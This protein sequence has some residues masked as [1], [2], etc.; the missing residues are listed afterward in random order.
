MN[1]NNVTM[2]ILGMRCGSCSSKVKSALLS[3]H[4]VDSV[5]V[6]FQKNIAVATTFLEVDKDLLRGAVAAAGEFSVEGFGESCE[7]RAHAL[8]IQTT[9]CVSD[10]SDVDTPSESLYPLFLIVGFILGVTLLIAQSTQDWSIESMMRHFMA[11]FFLVFSFFKLLNPSG[12]VSAFKMYD[13]LAKVIPGWAW[14]YPIVELFLGVA[15]LLAWFPALTNMLTL[16]LMVVGGGGVLHVLRQNKSIRCACLGTTLNLPMTKVTLVENGTMAAM[17]AVMLLGC[18]VTG[19][20]P[21]FEQF[22]LQDLQGLEITLMSIDGDRYPTKSPS[23]GADLLHGWT[24]LQRC[25]LDQH[26]Q[27]PHVLGILDQAMARG[28]RSVPVDCFNPRHAIRISSVESVKDFLICFQCRNYMVWV[29]GVRI[30]GGDIADDSK[31]T[32]NLIFESDCQHFSYH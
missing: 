2:H 18:G 20:R 31:D 3:V 8:P 23:I 7:S 24:V 16:F 5:Q 32:I 21:P 14:A 12:F 13:P 22:G 17:A 27:A 25:P 29:D 4:G 26:S 9:C 30:G 1:Q 15:Y 6:D 28:S 10:E 19:A 11:G